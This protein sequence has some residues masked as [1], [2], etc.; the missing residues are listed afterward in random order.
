MASRLI[1][2]YMR[3]AYLPHIWC[4]GCGNGIILRDVVQAVENLGIERRDTI[5]VSGIGPTGGPSPLR[6][7]S[8]WR[9]RS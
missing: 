4:A 5:I 7:A 1:E 2:K 3:G 9:G 6:R 8:R